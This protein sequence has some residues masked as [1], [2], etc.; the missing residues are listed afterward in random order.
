MNHKRVARVMRERG[1]AGLRLRRKARST[2]HEPADE[3]VADLLKRDFTAPAPN[4]K[5]VGDITYLPHGDGHTSGHL[6]LAT[7]IDCCSRRL[8]GWSIA[9]HMRTELVENALRAA[10]RER[11]SLL[12]AVFHADHGA[13]HVDCLHQPASR[14]RRRRLGRLGR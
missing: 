4:R 11:G 1:I 14:C 7:V 5:Y 3:K 10:Q 6:Y 12:G 13:I 9:E 8:V 2:I